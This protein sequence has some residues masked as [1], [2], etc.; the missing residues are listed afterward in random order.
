M[1]EGS[2]LIIDVSIEDAW[3]DPLASKGR[4]DL[5]CPDC[6][7]HA[8]V[9]KRS[10]YGLFYGCPSYEGTGC[11]GSVSADALGTPRG[12]PAPAKTR[13]LRKEI[14]TLAERY[15]ER[16]GGAIKDALRKV[17][18]DGVGVGQLEEDN[19]RQTAEKL[20]YELGEWSRWD[21]LRDED[22]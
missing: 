14:M 1:A 7:K 15:A 12:I 13:T 6:G 4:T 22:D 17:L 8:L 10:S 18:P 20:R 2:D 16:H 3:D 9:L 19:A 11:K 21:R 5:Q